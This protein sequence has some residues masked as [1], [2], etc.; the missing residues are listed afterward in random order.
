ML[1]STKVLGIAAGVAVL[2][3]V[4]FGAMRSA[5]PASRSVNQIAITA[6]NYAF[7]APD[8]VPAGLTR[9]EIAN[10]GTELHHVWLVRLDDGHTMQEFVDAFKS[11]GHPPEWA[12][13]AGGPNAA[14]PGASATALVNLVPGHYGVMCVIPS[15]DG[16]PHGMKG[17]M[18]ELVV[19]P[20]RGTTGDATEVA[21]DAQMTLLDYDFVMS[22]PLTAG[23]HVIQVHNGASQTHE[24]VVA[25]LLPGRTIRELAEW[26]EKMQGPPPGAP[27]G[28]SS[29][30]APGGDAE[31]VLNL[32]PGDYGFIC[33]VNDAKDGKPHVMH[34]MLKQFAVR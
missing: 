3:I 25:Q 34:G 9:I 33:F 21:P 30:I 14:V 8:S 10:K 31:I 32:T 29:G 2:A 20:A 19:T 26:A 23:R 18:R 16:V 6:R 28:G 12:H 7:D 4:G 27:I 24:V 1:M 17:M 22:K 11:S 5:K 13:D 15:T